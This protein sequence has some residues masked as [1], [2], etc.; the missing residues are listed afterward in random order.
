MSVGLQS[1]ASR[2][3]VSTGTVSKV[4][5]GYSGISERTRQKVLK[6]F[7]EL[8]ITPRKHLLG[9][10]IGQ[11]DATQNF[12]LIT[13]K[14]GVMAE[15]EAEPY[16]T[17]SRTFSSFQ[18]HLMKYGYHILLGCRYENDDVLM[19]YVRDNCGSRLDGLVF[20]SPPGERIGA[21]LD[22]RKVPGISLSSASLDCSHVTV[23]T[24]TQGSGVHRV[25]THL[26]KLGH[27][28][29]GFLGWRLNHEGYAER[30]QAYFSGMQ[31]GGIEY[32]PEIVYRAGAAELA[33]R[34]V[35][36][37]WDKQ[38][39]EVEAFVRRLLEQNKLPT[40]FV[41][42]NDDIAK[43]L[44]V[45]LGSR[46]LSV[47][48]DVSVAGWGNDFGEAEPALTTVD[49][50]SE[51]IGQVAARKII[52]MARNRKWIPVRIDVPVKLIVRSS[53]GPVC[54]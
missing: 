15:F 37:D 35:E 41:C 6:S 39:L 4:L 21:F 43:R 12:A 8:G 3:G 42:V 23:V 34:V 20:L 26:L 19:E 11:S 38:F 48:G 40:A 47:P 14:E 9:T 2:A 18:R 36:A 46:N 17:L 27:R 33:G 51:I 52:E 30:F 49:S 45:H 29:I 22:R 44:I 54:G 32:D 5:N 24:S 13:N 28:R 10:R 1:I 53:T 25:I 7:R 31:F 50:Q 16:R